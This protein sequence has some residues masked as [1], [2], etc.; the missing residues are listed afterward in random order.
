MRNGRAENA[1]RS[2]DALANVVLAVRV[3]GLDCGAGVGARAARRA[4]RAAL[5]LFR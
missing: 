2:I 5:R 4:L 3:G 1:D